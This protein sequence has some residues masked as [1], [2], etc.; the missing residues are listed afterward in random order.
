MRITIKDIAQQ[1][2]LSYSTVSRALH[3]EDS[4]YVSHKTRVLVRHVARQLGYVPN[5]AARSLVTGQT[6]TIA[7]MMIDAY[8]PFYAGVLRRLT[9][10]A[11]DHGF[12]V[13]I[14]RWSSPGAHDGPPDFLRWPVAGALAWDAMYVYADKMQFLRQH[15]L[16]VIEM[17]A[18][19]G[20]TGDRVVADLAGGTC[21]AIEHLLAGGRRRVGMMVNQ[22]SV[23]MDD[24]RAVAYRAV[25]AEAGL[26]PE[27]IIL[28]QQTRANARETIAAYGRAHTLPEALFCVNDDVA[29]GALRG[30]H[31]MGVRVP[32]DVALV[33]CDGIED[34]LYH[35]P[36]ISTLLHPVATMCDQ[37]LT[38]LANRIA[39]P[40]L[41]E[42]YALLPMELAAR[43][44]SA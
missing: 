27:W 42:Q 3:D 33:G 26:E 34:T 37:G 25:M 11:E 35:A 5:A 1:T 13:A 6:N 17:G 2:G 16:P 30:L 8:A 19:V 29:I 22:G 15:G 28:A 36:S 43:E 40:E 21:L 32:D 44:S 7:L 39:N 12:T 41:P 20:P 24:L 23:D 18:I 4:P 14:E 38:F 10:A 31:D 9:K